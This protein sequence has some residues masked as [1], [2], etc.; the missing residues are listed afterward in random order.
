M[1]KKADGITL[2]II[3]LI[4]I[5]VIGWGISIGT[6]ECNTKEDCEKGQYCSSDFKCIDMPIIEKEIIKQDLI[7]P[8]KIIA[9][10]IG[11]GGLFL[12][13]GY[14]FG[15]LISIFKPRKKRP[16]MKDNFQQFY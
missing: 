5:V 4:I 13:I 7:M 9:I 14:A 1:N 12:G 11:I 2:A 8:A 10:G 16:R 3:I 15:N 6:R